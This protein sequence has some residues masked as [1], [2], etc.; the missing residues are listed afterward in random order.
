MFEIII[1]YFFVK[2]VVESNGKLVLKIVVLWFEFLF[3]KIGDVLKKYLE[4]KNVG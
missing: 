1:V 3:D 4:D 2:M